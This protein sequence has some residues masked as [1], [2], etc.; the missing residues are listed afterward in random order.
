[1]K[2][3][4]AGLERLAGPTTAPTPEQIEA[5]LA[6]G[7][8]ALRRRRVFQSAAGSAFA[9]AAV[10]AAFA[11]A[12]SGGAVPSPGA[13]QPQAKAPATATEAPQSGP[14][15]EL[16]SYKG[17]QPKGFILDKVP[18]G[19]EVQGV[20]AGVLTLAPIGIA[21]QE[22]HSFQGKVA[23]MLQS[24]DE[25]GAPNGKKVK[26]GKYT[27]Y[28]GKY[29]DQT[30]GF[31]LLVDRGKEPRLQIQVWDDLGWTGDQVVEFAAGITVTKD[32]Q[33]GH[34]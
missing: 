18:D 20:D 11:F 5:D 16:V 15:I 3:L 29:Q 10:A 33:P 9:V 28:L 31:N 2:N 26:V 32:A 30:T 21:D 6:R 27:G 24:V 17:D 22:M 25:H 13:T 23:V 4:Y 34:G 14:S 19:W 12:T 8:G 7:R 1:M